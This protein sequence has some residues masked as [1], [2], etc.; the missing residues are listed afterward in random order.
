MDIVIDSQQRE[1]LSCLFEAKLY[2]YKLKLLQNDLN[3]TPN[4]TKLDS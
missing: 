3:T 4:F 2:V 1:I